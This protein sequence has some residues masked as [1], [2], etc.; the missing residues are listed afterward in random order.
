M[1]VKEENESKQYPQNT[2]IRRVKRGSFWNKSGPVRI[3]IDDWNKWRW[4]KSDAR[5]VRHKPRRL[6]STARSKKTE[7]RDINVTSYG[8][9]VI[10]INKMTNVRRRGKIKSTCL[11]HFFPSPVRKPPRVGSGVKT[12]E[13]KHL[14]NLAFSDPSSREKIA[15]SP[16]SLQGYCL[17]GNTDVVSLT[18]E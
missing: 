18:N 11:C 4:F 3:S 2:D 8:R 5:F 12:V 1:I 9:H 13:K 10:W 6:T 17:D 7:S 14:K 16:N 15:I